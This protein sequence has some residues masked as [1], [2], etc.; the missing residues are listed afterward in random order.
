[1]TTQFGRYQVK[2]QLG[3]G[4]MAT[5]YLAY[6]PRFDRDVALKV[7]HLPSL[8]GG[9]VE[10]WLGPALEPTKDANQ[11]NYSRK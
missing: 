10:R 4:G 6:D 9:Q 8:P 5:V 7:L 2:R 11:G 3:Q 1:M